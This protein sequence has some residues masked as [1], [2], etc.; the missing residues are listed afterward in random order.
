MYGA[1]KVAFGRVQRLG[2]NLKMRGIGQVFVPLPG[3]DRLKADAHQLGQLL[4]RQSAQLSRL[5]N[6]A[7]QTHHGSL[8]LTLQLYHAP[9]TASNR[10]GL[11][12]Q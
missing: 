5:C 11:K 9:K 12:I 1:V 3:A 10:P 7:S 2:Q 4:L 6:V 8:L